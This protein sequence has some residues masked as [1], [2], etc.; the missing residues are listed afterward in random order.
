MEVQAGRAGRRWAGLTAVLA[1]AVAVPVLAHTRLDRAT[2]APDSTVEVAPAQ[3][4]LEFSEPVDPALA[5]V[6]VE[7]D[8][9]PGRDLAD[10]KRGET[11][12]TLVAAVPA[13]MPAG[14]WT[15]RWQVAGPDG[16]PVR[17]SYVVTVLAARV[18]PNPVEA[19]PVVTQERSAHEDDVMT[20]ESSAYVAARWL[21]FA[22]MLSVIGAVAFQLLVLRP[23]RLRAPAVAGAFE[24]AAEHAARLGYGAGLFLALAAGV[25]LLL[26]IEALGGGGLEMATL[27][28]FETT[29]GV[30]WFTHVSGALVAMSGFRMAM[31]GRT[32]AWAVAAAGALLIAIGASLSGHAAAAELTVLAVTADMV[33]VLAVSG[34]IGALLVLAL[35]G[36]PTVYAEDPRSGRFSGIC[37]LVFAFSPRALVMAGI[38][39]VTGVF[40]AWLHLPTLASL[41]SSDYGRMLIAK[42]FLVGLTA[43]IGAWN[44][45]R[46]KPGL[47][48]GDPPERLQRTAAAELAVSALVLLVTAILV[49]LPTP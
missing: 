22:A 43:A 9:G 21:T 49:A 39:T 27:V 10:L 38:A 34:W 8:G 18:A 26:Q 14:V 3:L 4:V 46:M 36:I 35:V 30:A 44:W 23:A 15:V 2:P 16:H 33:H 42:V 45:K 20:V 19:P 13:A 7:V 48:A 17:G 24:L 37:A 41:W 29:W 32:K 25:R 6:A 5:R 12:S 1:L 47:E 28:L 31:R 11:D 40:G